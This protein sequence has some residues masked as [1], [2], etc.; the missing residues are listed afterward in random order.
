M[1]RV[2]TTQTCRYCTLAKTAL[3][4]RGLDYE[5]V[6]VTDEIRAQLFAIGLRTVPQIYLHEPDTLVPVHLGGYDDL[7]R[8]LAN[9]EV[10]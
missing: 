5:E 7:M 8:H 1:Y 10:V 4:A 9:L 2:F 3:D 6:E